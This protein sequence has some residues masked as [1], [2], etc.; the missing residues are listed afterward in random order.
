MAK[1]REP[2]RIYPKR[3]IPFKNGLMKRDY[4]AVVG[5]VSDL[6]NMEINGESIQKRRGTKLLLPDD[7]TPRIW[8]LTPNGMV[9]MT[10]AGSTFMIGVDQFNKIY[11]VC[12]AFPECEFEVYSRW[13]LNTATEVSFGRGDRF[14]FLDGTKFCYIVNNYYDIYRIDKAGAIE[15]W[16]DDKD[17]ITGTTYRY[18]TAANDV[19]VKVPASQR[20]K[21]YLDVIDITHGEIED[22]YVIDDI[23]QKF[24]PVKGQIYG[25]I[26]NNAG[27]FGPWKELTVLPEYKSCYFSLLPGY[28]I[29]TEDNRVNVGFNSI[30]DSSTAVTDVLFAGYSGGSARVSTSFSS[31]S[32]PSTTYTSVIIAKDIFGEEGLFMFVDHTIVAGVPQTGTINPTPSNSGTAY[33][34]F[35]PTHY[36]EITTCEVGRIAIDT[37]TSPDTFALKLVKVESGFPILVEEDVT[38]DFPDYV[39]SL[40]GSSYQG[41]FG[42]SLFEVDTLTVGPTNTY[43]KVYK[44]KSKWLEDLAEEHSLKGEAAWVTS[45]GLYQAK[46]LFKVHVKSNVNLTFKDITG[47][48]F[49]YK[50]LG[51]DLWETISQVTVNASDF[52]YD[53]DENILKLDS[54]FDDTSVIVKDE[55]SRNDGD[56]FAIWSD[57]RILRVSQRAHSEPGVGTGIENII[58]E[59]DYTNIFSDSSEKEM[60][61]MPVMAMDYWSLEAAVAPLPKAQWLPKNVEAIAMGLGATFVYDGDKIYIT[62]ETFVAENY[63]EVSSK[64][65]HLVRIFDGCLAFTV[66]DVYRIS[67][68]GN[69]FY[70]PKGSPAKAVYFFEGAVVAVHKDNNI[71]IYQVYYR[72][73]G[74]PDIRVDIISEPIKEIPWDDPKLAYANETIWVADGN[75]IYGFYEGGWKKQFEFDYNIK[76]ISALEDKLLINFAFGDIDLTLW[77]K[78]FSGGIIILS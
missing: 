11:T 59:S 65:E 17:F 34:E 68:N 72:E 44:V 73:N 6:K 32:N 70:I 54:D 42:T 25:S 49:A 66:N 69:K 10:V 56:R 46:A 52:E 58:Y 8:Q 19:S 48:N 4:D 22:I 62:D 30:E 27:Q 13:E 9:E 15:W 53:I 55:E 61:N 1:L 43:R 51:F 23:D 5:F 37:T 31:N 64:V 41:Y 7:D 28:S 77:A 40:T 67:P 26:V 57:G 75:R 33:N 60:Y 18:N 76:T 78:D 12:T 36:A 38:A 2:K 16:F 35:N 63:V 74:A 29:G 45:S 14:W 71:A 20:G 21:V 24:R 47:V 3:K 50:H 39:Y